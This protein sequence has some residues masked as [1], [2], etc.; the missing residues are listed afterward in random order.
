MKKFVFLLV[1]CLGLALSFVGLQ[2]RAFF[3]EV[4]ETGT[5]ETVSVTADEREIAEESAETLASGFDFTY[6]E[7]ESIDMY[8]ILFD[9]GSVVPSLVYDP[10]ANN[11]IRDIAMSK[12]FDLGINSGYFTEAFTHVGLLNI[13]GE[14]YVPLSRNN[15][16]LTHLVQFD[17]TGSIDILDADTYSDFSSGINSSAFQT[18]PIIL[19]NNVIQT[20]EIASSLNGSG[21]FLRSFL[22]IT[23]SGKGFIGIVNSLV[24]LEELGES[25][26]ELD[27]FT[28]ETLTVVNL[29]GG[30]SLS[31][32]SEENEDF[33]FGTYKNLPNFLGFRVK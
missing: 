29:D 10:S 16:Q 9:Q 18:G 11:S 31:L 17:A 20:E 7:D 33:R 26:L 8:I 1:I 15:V 19:E 23:D 21:S 12:D 13:S 24:S 14:G 4:D 3:E 6:I 22:G 30:G 2:V 5:N 27:F 25:L 32:Y 28:G